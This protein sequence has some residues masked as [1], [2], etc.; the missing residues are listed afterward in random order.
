VLHFVVGG[1]LS[2]LPWPFLPF[3]PEQTPQ[4]YGAHAVY[5]ACQVPLLVALLRNRRGQAT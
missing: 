1:L 5:A 4:H 3:L 2:V